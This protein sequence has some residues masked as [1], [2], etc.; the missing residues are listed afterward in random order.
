MEKKIS[1]YDVQIIQYHERKCNMTYFA[2][3]LIYVEHFSE[4]FL[5]TYC[6]GIAILRPWKEMPFPSCSCASPLTILSIILLSSSAIFFF[7]GGTKT[8]LRPMPPHF[9][10]VH[11]THIYTYIPG[12]T[13]L[14]E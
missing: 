10:H 6:T 1:M 13:P 2:P 3:V 11:I 5:K 12:R 9:L 4:T 8:Q 14:N 7:C